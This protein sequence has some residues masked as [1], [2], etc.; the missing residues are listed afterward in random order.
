MYLHVLGPD[1][2]AA[3]LFVAMALLAAVLSAAGLVLQ[4][5]AVALFVALLMQNH[6]L[7]LLCEVAADL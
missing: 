3:T 7:G 2:M 1:G 4:M 5:L 6:W